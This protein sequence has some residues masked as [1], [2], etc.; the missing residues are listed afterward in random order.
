MISRERAMTIARRMQALVAESLRENIRGQMSGVGQPFA[1]LWADT[2]E[3]PKGQKSDRAGQPVLMDSGRLLAS[4]QPGAAVMEGR[5]ILCFIDAEPYGLD[6]HYGFISEPQ[7]WIGR[8]LPVRESIRGGGGSLW[9]ARR[10]GDVVV[11]NKALAVPP[12]PWIS[13]SEAKARSIAQS[14]IRG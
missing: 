10:R 4:I 3:F 7:N 2:A 11:S 1:R 12:R 8:T 14:A 9:A 5:A 6:Q 13:V